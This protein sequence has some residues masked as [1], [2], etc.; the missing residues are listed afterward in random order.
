MLRS[1]DSLVLLVV[2]ALPNIVLAQEMVSPG[3]SAPAGGGAAPGGSAAPPSSAVGP[4]EMIIV[5]LVV[6][7]IAGFVIT[8]FARRRSRDEHLK[9]PR[10]TATG[11]ASRRREELND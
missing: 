5:G 11:A 8:R 2:L 6:L 9:L 10:N 3:D 1:L 4:A 7:L